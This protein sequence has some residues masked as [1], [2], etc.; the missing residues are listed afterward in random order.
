MDFLTSLKRQSLALAVCNILIG[1]FF[2]AFPGTAASTIVRIIAVAALVAGVVQIVAFFSSSKYERPY[3]NLLTGGV[4]LAALSVFMLIQ[5]QTIVSILY[6]I[7]G[8]FLIIDGIISVQNAID[9]RRFSGRINWALLVFGAV[10]LILG[11]IVLFNPF[12]SAKILT[13]TSG[14]FMLIGGIGDLIALAS[15]HSAFKS[16]K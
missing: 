15:I 2:V 1:I 6:V 14:I 5:P 7:I 12:T 10:V 16:S 4:I 13:L 11:I 9:L 3:G 8:A